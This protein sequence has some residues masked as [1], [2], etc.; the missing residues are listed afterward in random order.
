[1]LVSYTYRS[2]DPSAEPGDGS[3]VKRVA[4]KAPETKTFAFYTVVDLGAIVPKEEVKLD[5][6]F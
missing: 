4:E 5:S 6:D 3:P 2:D 1:M